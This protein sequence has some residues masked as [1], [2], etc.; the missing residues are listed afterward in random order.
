MFSILVRFSDGSGLLRLSV[1]AS[2]DGLPLM[3]HPSL[4]KVVSGT[5]SWIERRG[6][7]PSLTSE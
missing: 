7:K 4:L 3:C 2:E 6:K 5:S 1:V